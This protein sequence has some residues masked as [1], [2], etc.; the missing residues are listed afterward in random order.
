MKHVQAAPQSWVK[1]E[2]LTVAKRDKRGAREILQAQLDYALSDE[3]YT[4]DKA[5]R[6]FLRMDFSSLT[7]ACGDISYLRQLTLFGDDNARCHAASAADLIH[8][9]LLSELGSDIY[10]LLP[11]PWGSE[12]YY[13]LETP[14][15]ILEHI[16]SF[17]G[18]FRR[19]GQRR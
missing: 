9:N 15:Y 13:I 1:V 11:Y 8:R 14:D 2:G 12:L 6:K 10:F 18:D 4:S 16:G 19:W 17:D 7:N 3:A 5:R